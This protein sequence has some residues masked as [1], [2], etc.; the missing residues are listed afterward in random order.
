MELIGLG[1]IIVLLI[2]AFFMLC[3]VI[4]FGEDVFLFLFIDSGFSHFVVENRYALLGGMCFLLT[5]CYLVYFKPHQAEK[6]FM[7]YK[8]NRIT[9]QEAI[10][11]IADT[12]YKPASQELPSVMNSKLTE[13]RIKAL[14][15]RVQA[16]EAFI[17]DL[18]NYIRTKER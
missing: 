16:E 9:R 7:Q 12:M 10:M 2:V 18:K 3:Q 11:K 1:L 8:A 6:Y 4:S 14:R 5:A 13:K 17:H 15:R